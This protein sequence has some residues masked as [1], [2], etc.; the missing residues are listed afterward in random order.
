MNQLEQLKQWT[1][2]VAD[3]GDF[4]SIVQFNPVDATT[5]PSLILKACLMPKY[6]AIIQSVIKEN[7]K[8]SLEILLDL[9]IVHFGCKILE[10]VPGRVSTEIDA[11]LSF[12]KEKS[13]KKALSIIELY[14]SYGHSR[15]RILIKLAA[16]WEG[17]EAAKE[18][19]KQNIH[20]NLT[21]LFSLSQA[22]ACAE[23][24]IT[25]ISPFVGRILDWHKKNNPNLDPNLDPG[26]LSV[27]EIY[28][29]LKKYG[30]KTQIMGAS[31]RNKQEIIDL[32][33]CDLLTISPDL[34]SQLKSSN[35]PIQRELLPISKTIQ[36]PNP[37]TE[38]E[39]R[40]N[41]NDNAMAT[42]KLAEGIRLFTKDI[43][44][45]E[46]IIDKIRSDSI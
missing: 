22:I 45:L 11:R 2:I 33:G 21:L 44:E 20:C 32:S 43:L 7:P 41:L 12:D 38:K 5:N 25:L 18:L 14:E 42:E 8:A 26:V 10:I 16:T 30:F 24:N 36:K 23:G 28:H 31:F 17:I 46:K 27:K 4:E 34:L 19:E 29:H 9:L 39:F 37:I 15:N 6:K 13:F 3:T 35:E 1:K 40:W